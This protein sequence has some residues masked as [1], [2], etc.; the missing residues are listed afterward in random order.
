MNVI[1][2]DNQFLG[3]EHSGRKVAEYVEAFS[4]EQKIVDTL[5]L[6][7][8]AGLREYAFTATPKMLNVLSSISEEYPFLLHPAF[9]YAQAVNKK[10]ADMGFIGAFADVVRSSSVWA[11]LGA[12][13]TSLRHDYRRA[14]DLYIRYE[15]Q[16]INWD[17][18]SSIGLL[19]VAT[20]FLLG[21]R[22][23]DILD[24]FCSVVRQQY[25][26]TPV[27]YTMNFPRLA[28]SV[29]PE[30]NHGTR[31]I[32]NFNEKGFRTNPS[33]KDVIQAVEAHHG[34]EIYIMSLYSGRGKTDPHE[35]L[36]RYPGIKGVLFGS[37]NP[38]RI[39]RNFQALASLKSE[40]DTQGYASA[41]YR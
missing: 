39:G 27:L 17:R 26:K 28:A 5:R 36:A 24:Q 16:G 34:R 19:N 40:N 41:S 30:D 10:L 13:A 37:S 22:R 3:V 25:G 31:M 38:V 9:P 29:W 23:E 33:L 35:F 18:V 8:D 2:G 12:A 4:S 20:D 15:L 14:V 32:F 11:V 6:A 1:F 21:L 7:W